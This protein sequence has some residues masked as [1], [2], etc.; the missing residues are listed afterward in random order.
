MNTYDIKKNLGLTYWIKLMLCILIII[1]SYR[2]DNN[3]FHS[4]V[5]GMYMLSVFTVLFLLQRRTHNLL[6]TVIVSI[7][8][9]IA[10]IKLPIPGIIISA[11]MLVMMFLGIL[12]DCFQWVRLIEISYDCKHGNKEKWLELD[13]MVKSS[14]HYSDAEKKQSF[15]IS[16]SSQ[17]HKEGNELAVKMANDIVASE[18]I[19]VELNT[20]ANNSDVSTLFGEYNAIITESKD[21]RSYFEFLDSYSSD[22]NVESDKYEVMRDYFNRFQR[23]R[24]R[25]D[26]LQHKYLGTGNSATKA[27][28]AAN[29]FNGCNSMESLQ[30]RYK[31]LCK[32]Y[33]PDMG[34]GSAEIFTE[35]QAAYEFLKKKYE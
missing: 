14:K 25:L 18:K 16:V 34:N 15:F 30:K 32:V 19:W 23:I 5:V 9:L 17:K 29:Y 26:E 22:P 11:M 27:T 24:K 10:L 31:D 8:A 7:V 1:F 33:H 35:I 20:Y 12:Y 4:I 3:L 28:T 21:I 13:K 2:G 6:V